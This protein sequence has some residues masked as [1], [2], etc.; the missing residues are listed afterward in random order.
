MVDVRAGML[1][2][3]SP[4]LLDPN[5]TDTVVLVLDADADGAMGVVIN[6]PSPV[7]VVSVLDGWDDIVAEPE[8][9]FRGGPVSPDGALAVA[10][11]RERHAVPPGL[12]PVT[13]RLAIVDLQ[14]EAEDIDGAV[15]GVRIFAGYAGWGSGQLEA[16]IEGGD[17]Y[18][19]PSLPPDPFQP[20]PS[21]LWREVMRRQP[22]ELAW[23]V[24]RPVDPELN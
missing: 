6:R 19:V 21:D 22:G 18:A 13:D 17:W 9:L 7:P 20:D 16:E 11:L 10:L 12:R 14:G 23:H 5:F 8:V 2:V 1:L 15:E 3:A 4:E 24:N